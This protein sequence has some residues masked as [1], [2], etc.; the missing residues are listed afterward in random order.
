MNA[1]AMHEKFLDCLSELD[2]T[3]RNFHNILQRSSKPQ[4]QQWVRDQL[5]LLKETRTWYQRK[6]I[7]SK[8]GSDERAK[9]INDFCRFVETDCAMMVDYA[10]LKKIW[11]FAN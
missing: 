7:E 4:H 3:M 11:K 1:A 2:G 10:Q 8:R 6:I 5:N 9:F